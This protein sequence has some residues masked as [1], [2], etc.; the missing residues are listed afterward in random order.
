MIAA[1][2]SALGNY[3]DIFDERAPMEAAEE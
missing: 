3:A 2:I 1:A